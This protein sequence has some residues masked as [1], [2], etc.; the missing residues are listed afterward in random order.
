MA[1]AFVA[2]EGFWW[3]R[4]IWENGGRCYCGGAPEVWELS[5]HIVA[6]RECRGEPRT[7]TSDG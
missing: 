7:E 3:E 5:G 1:P 4:G 2:H 6:C